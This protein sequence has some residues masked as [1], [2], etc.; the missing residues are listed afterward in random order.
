MKYMQ[1]LI[2]KSSTNIII[3]GAGTLGRIVYYELLK[4]TN[5]NI[6][7]WADQRYENINDAPMKIINPQYIKNYSYNFI[8]LALNKELTNI[9]INEKIVILHKKD[10]FHM[11]ENEINYIILNDDFA[12]K[13]FVRRILS[14]NFSNNKLEL[15]IYKFFICCSRIKYWNGSVEQ[16]HWYMDKKKNIAY[17]RLAKCACT[18]IINSLDGKEAKD[19]YA[20]L[21]T[22]E[23]IY[24]NNSMFKFT[25]VRNPF[26]RLV[27][28]YTDKIE[29]KKENNSYKQI[30][31]CMGILNTIQNFEEFV[32][33]IVK[34]PGRWADRHFKPQ[35]CHIYENGKKLVD[36]IG[37]IEEITTTYEFI[38]KKYGLNDLRILNTSNKRNWMFYYTKETAKLVYEYYK[39]D[40]LT[41][42]YE[43]DYYQLLKYLNNK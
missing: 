13:N 29:N 23:Y 1:L 5:I 9:E 2:T 4:N 6:V 8:I 14:E 37:K 42:G 31:Y 11:M 16:R 10:I 39:D 36:Y 3:Y 41:F 19:R 30:N 12:R 28:C 43:D 34:I 18:S 15:E 25:Y 21:W 40:I 20:Y 32:K 17:L 35:Y 7:A 33:C 27:S 26:E 22:D 24:K 38:Q